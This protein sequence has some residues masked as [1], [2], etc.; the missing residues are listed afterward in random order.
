MLTF[1]EHAKL[2]AKR[3]FLQSGVITASLHNPTPA[4]APQIHP[5]HRGCNSDAASGSLLS[6][7]KM[8]SRPPRFD[9]IDVTPPST[10]A[11]V[12]RWAP[13]PCPRLAPREPVGGGLGTGRHRVPRARHRTCPGT[14]KKQ[15]SA[16]VRFRHHPPPAPPSAAPVAA[17]SLPSPPGADWSPQPG[18]DWASMGRWNGSC[19]RKSERARACKCVHMHAT[20]HTPPMRA[21]RRRF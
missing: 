6:R 5:R 19:C 2:P 10:P 11:A 21:L 13:R 8:P 17:G 9:S 18:A 16:K 7:F 4:R 15:A 12:G 3:P 20:T 1:A 14:C